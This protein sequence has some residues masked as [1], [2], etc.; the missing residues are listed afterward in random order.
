MLTLVV[1]TDTEYIIILRE[2]DKHQTEVLFEHTKRLRAGNLLIEPK[3]EKERELAFFKKKSRSKSRTRK[4][5]IL[6]YT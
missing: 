1:Q 5:G 2:M 6:E 4:F 3:K